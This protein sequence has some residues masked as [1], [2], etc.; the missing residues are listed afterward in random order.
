MATAVVVG[1]TIGSGV[2][3]KAQ[4]VSPNVPGPGFGWAAVAWVFVGVLALLGGLTIAEVAGLLSPRRRRLR[5]PARGYGRL[6]GF[7]WGWVEFWIIRSASIA[8][9]ATIFSESLFNVLRDPAL[10]CRLGYSPNI[11]G[12]DPGQRRSTRPWP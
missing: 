7:L 9:L 6:A 4:V 5:L 8:A 12:L 1:T 10:A 11:P 3:K 2:F